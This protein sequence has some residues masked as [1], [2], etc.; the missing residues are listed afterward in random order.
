LAPNSGTVRPIGYT[1]QAMEDLQ[2]LWIPVGAFAI[3]GAI[4][5]M[6]FVF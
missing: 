5:L 3:V 4:M 6:F 1:V 2:L